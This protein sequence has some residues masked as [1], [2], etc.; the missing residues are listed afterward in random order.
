MGAVVYLASYMNIL[1]FALNTCPSA[2]SKRPPQHGRPP[3]RALLALCV[4]CCSGRPCSF[5]SSARTCT[6]RRPRRRAS[7]SPRP[8]AGRGRCA[9]TQRITARACTSAH[10]CAQPRCHSYA[11]SDTCTR[12]ARTLVRA[13]LQLLVVG[14]LLDDVED[15]DRELRVRKS[16]ITC[17]VF[18]IPNMMAKPFGIFSK[19][20]S[21]E[22]V[23]DTLRSLRRRTCFDL[24]L[25]FLRARLANA[26]AATPTSVPSR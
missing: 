5:R 1:T 16:A 15:G 13:L 6:P 9:P 19:S 4:R 2:S 24:L 17:R 12:A 10:T 14:R 11:E 26:S 22:D 20:I 25:T 21:S 23:P 18:L 7:C 3:D 8:T